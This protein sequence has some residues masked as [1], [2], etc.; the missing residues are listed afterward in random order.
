MILLSRYLE[1]FT[2][3]FFPK[4]CLTCGST[5]TGDERVICSACR[6]SLPETGYHLSGNNPVEELFIGRLKTEK[7]YSL[8][9]FDKG[10]KYRKLIHQLKYKGRK[11]AGEFLGQLMG[12]RLLDCQFPSVDMIVPVPLHNARLRRRG[13]NQS[14]ILAQGISSVIQKPVNENVLRRTK[15]TS[16][17][18]KRGRYER[19]KNVEGL[20]TCPEPLPIENKHILLVDDVVTTGSTLEA[21][22]SSLLQHKGVRISIATAAYATV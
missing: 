3:L 2:D 16:T 20:F 17:Q 14:T 1:S 12:S 18:T 9:F 22:G 19:W 13:F 15:Y 6:L 21:A 10:S 4:V 11:D 8:L 5:L 7:A